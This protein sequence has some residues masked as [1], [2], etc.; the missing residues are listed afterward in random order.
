MEADE[1]DRETLLISRIR[2][3]DREALGDLLQDQRDSLLAF[4]K[5]ITGAHL[6]RVVTLEDLYQEVATSAITALEKIANPTL[7]PDSW[8]R[9]LCRRRVADAHRFH[10][11]AERRAANRVQ[12]MGGHGDQSELG[13]EQLLIASIT[14]PSAVV[15]RDMRMARAAAAIASLGQE[16]AEVI[17]LRYVEGLGTKEIAEKLGKSDVSIRVLLSRSMSKLSELLADKD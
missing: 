5:H 15:S 11:G 16:T 14:S 12:G 2:T 6:L 7:D 13:L 9:Q 10:F 4:L 1:S 3:G 8:L 17:R